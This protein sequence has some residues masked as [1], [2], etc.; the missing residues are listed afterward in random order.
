[1]E[2]RMMVPDPG[3]VRFEGELVSEIDVVLGAGGGSGR[4]DDAV[5]Q[6]RTLLDFGAGPENGGQDGGIGPDGSTR[7]DC[8]GLHH[9]RGVNVSLGVAQLT[10]LSVVVG[11]EIGF[12]GAQIEPDPLVV[13]GGAQ[14]AVA[15]EVQEGGDDGDFFGG[16]DAL[17]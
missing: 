13:K 14:F 12:A 5:C 3:L 15:N 6:L 8:G 1:M 17:E 16:G 2:C 9:G 11:I 10:Q 4:I 7:A